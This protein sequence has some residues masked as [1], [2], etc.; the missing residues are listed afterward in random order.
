MEYVR[1]RFGAEF[2]WLTDDN[3]AFGP[4]S[5][6]LFHEINQRNLGD[7]LYWFV[8]ARVD[9]VAR[10]R[11]MIPEM[12]RAGNHWVLLGVESGDPEALANYG[13]GTKP[14]QA[15]EAIKV[16]KKNDIFA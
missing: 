9:D 13:K 6:E 4:R 14:G 11:E 5:K 10:N 8:Q 12:R 7:E 2:V 16:L 3:F 1:E 15:R